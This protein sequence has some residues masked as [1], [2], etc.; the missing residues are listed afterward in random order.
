[1]SVSIAFTE[2]NF[3]AGVGLLVVH[4]RRVQFSKQHFLSACLYVNAE[5][6]TSN[7]E[8][9]LKMCHVLQYRMANRHGKRQ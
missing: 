7:G 6:V 3:W 2:N 9:I 4:H 1:M 5:A 8:A